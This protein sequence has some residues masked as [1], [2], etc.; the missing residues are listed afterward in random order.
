M[1]LACAVWLV[2]A[3]PGC[4]PSALTKTKLERSFA[5]TFA[6]LIA[7]QE[8]LL[9]LPGVEARVFGASAGCHRLGPGD[10][11]SGSGQWICTV[12]WSIPGRG[13]ALRDTYDLAVTADGCFTAT[14]DGAEA[15]VG[16]ATRKT[17]QGASVINLLYTFDGCFDP[18]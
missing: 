10:R 17:A 5:P 9:G 15:H 8:S 13:G 11:P 6:N 18:T 14:A 16:G 7:T 4:G 1:R 2:I 12:Q 3:T